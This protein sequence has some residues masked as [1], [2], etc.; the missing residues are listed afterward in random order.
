M[1]LSII[2]PVFNEQ[3][4]IKEII[5]R[6]K[7][8]K[9]PKKVTKEIVVVNDASTDG[10]LEILKQIKNIKV[11]NHKINLG[12][13]AAIKTG[14]K[15]SFGEI[16]I[17]QDADLEYD[18]N[19]F[20]HLLKPILE[21]KTK[22]VYGT[23]LKNYPLRIFGK[24]RTPLVAHYLG[25]KLL[26]FFTNLIYHNGLTDMETGYKV[27]NRSILKGI[28]LNSRRFDFEPE[29]TAK[30]LKRGLEI[31]EVPIKVNPRGYD[32]GKKIT[33][34]DGLVALITLIKYRF[35]D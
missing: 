31:Y 10:T 29:I 28:K 2:I 16:I 8:V 11:V 13:G 19:Y 17:I 30:I 23:R 26:S 3:S 35:F 6:V 4:T 12:K 25:N 27:F 5:K 34:K 21:R 1:R 15:N 14:L 22:V 18:P 20:P 7:K 24:R 9:L 32:D 33:W